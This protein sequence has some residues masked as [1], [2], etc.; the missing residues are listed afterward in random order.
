VRIR[1][2]RGLGPKSEEQLE[3]VGINTSE[4][5]RAIGAV[6]AF[7]ALCETSASKPSLNFLYALVGALEDRDWQEV[8]RQDRGRLFAELEG[9]KELRRLFDEG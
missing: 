6:A 9:H 1:N 5:L 8:A 4:E 2:L 3:K 7:V